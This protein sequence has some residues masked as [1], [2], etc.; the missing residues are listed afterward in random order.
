MKTALDCYG[1]GKQ[2]ESDADEYTVGSFY[3]RER[4]ICPECGEFVHLR[5]SKYSNYFAHYKRQNTTAECDR[6]VGG[7]PTDS[8]YERIGLPIYIRSVGKDAF[9]LNL[10]FKAL[11]ESL[12]KDAEQYKIKVSI[13]CEKSY[14]VNRE[15]FSEKGT[16]L[17]PIHHIPK[18]ER[19]YRLLYS[20]AD[21]ATRIIK[22][23]ADYADGFSYEGAFFTI[24]EQG[25]KKI[26]HGDNISTEVEY[27]WIRKSSYIPNM[28]GLKSE[29]IGILRL[30]DDSWFVYKVILS[31]NISDS[32][33]EHLAYYFREHLKLYLLEKEPK[34]I[35]LWPPLIKQ[36]DEYLVDDDIR[37]KVYGCV[38]SGNDEPKTYI[39]NGVLSIPREINYREKMLAVNIDTNDVLINIDRKYISSGTRFRKALYDLNSEDSLLE[40]LCNSEVF[41]IDH[42][43]IE[44]DSIPDEILGIDSKIV[45]AVGADGKIQLVKNWNTNL[46]IGC[47]M[48]GATLYILSS[49]SLN[50]IIR[51]KIKKKENAG[52]DEESILKSIALLRNAVQ[53]YMPKNLSIQLSKVK[54]KNREVQEYMLECVRKNRIPLPLVRALEGMLNETI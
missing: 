30:Q 29:K 26:H 22:H 39:Y 45:F 50:S 34:Y 46:D 16:V 27:Y 51:I 40:V 20:P 25:G 19:R 37:S 10:G 5:R 41:E 47:L 49:M 28:S 2:K 48:D 53:V 36:E 3:S 15:R 13:D 14:F 31:S 38:M 23:W 17:I 33:F 4:F 9:E 7:E 18:L 24:S 54:W 42:K 8:I 43:V 44:L 35:P 12:M 6:R 21:K 11:P 1:R 32:A 52:C